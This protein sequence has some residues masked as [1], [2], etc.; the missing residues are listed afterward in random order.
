MAAI[1]GKEEH[2]SFKRRMLENIP[3]P[4]KQA[5]KPAQVARSSNSK[6]R[7]QSQGQNKGNG[8]ALATTPY[9][10]GYCIQ[11]IQQDTME[12]VFQM[13]RTIIEMQKREEARSKY[14]K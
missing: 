9:R 3:P 10:K 2:D 14:Q 1:V 11:N 13:A 12:N 6:I 8:K 5:P 4:P 7:K